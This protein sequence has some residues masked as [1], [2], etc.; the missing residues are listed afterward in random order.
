[1]SY[2]DYEKNTLKGGVF[3]T[4]I[5]DMYRVSLVPSAALSGVPNHTKRTPD[6]AKTK[7]ALC[8][9]RQKII[10]LAYCNDWQYFFTATFDKQKVEN[11]EEK[12]GC[13]KQLIKWLQ[14]KSRTH[15]IKY[16][17][18]PE[19]HKD[20][21]G[22][23][24]HGLLYF[25]RPPNTIPFKEIKARAIPDKLRESDFLNWVDY[26]KKF[27]FCSLGE[28]KSKKAISFYMSKYITKDLANAIKDFNA[29]TYYASKGLNAGVKVGGFH[30]SNANIDLMQTMPWTFKD[31][32]K[33]TASMT[34][35]STEELLEI[36]RENRLELIHAPKA[37]DS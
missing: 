18:I 27:G 8:R 25:E 16:L 1:M 13:L 5:G 6:N 11:R 37:D 20:G 33:G 15:G 36:L 17:L 29:H 23:H 9:A 35:Q 32:E 30:N 24:A 3:I 12:S 28:I 4:K 2:M 19:L 10:E 31:E 21:K 26:E 34:I 7:E 22:L 14:N